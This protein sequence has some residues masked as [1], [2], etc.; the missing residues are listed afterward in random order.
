MKLNMNFDPSLTI[1]QI[2]SNNNS[3]SLSLHFS[4]AKHLFVLQAPAHSGVNSEKKWVF[5]FEESVL[6]GACEKIKIL[7]KTLI[8]VLEVIAPTF[9]IYPHIYCTIF[10]FIAQCAALK[11][12]RAYLFDTLQEAFFE[13]GRIEL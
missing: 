13:I 6:K 2:Y 4:P 10:P 12:L 5:C 9:I 1:L 8:L 3:F 7:Q 11:F